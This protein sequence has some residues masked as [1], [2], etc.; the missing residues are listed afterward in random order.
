MK[1]ESSV[2]VSSCVDRRRFYAAVGASGALAMVAATA[3]VALAMPAAAPGCAKFAALKGVFPKPN[4][5]G[6]TARERIVRGEIRAPVWPGTCGKWF[7]RYRRGS[8]GVDVS[9][10]LYKTHE[11][12]LVALAE[13]LSAQ[14][15]RLSN[16]ALVRTSRSN[17]SVNGIAKKDASVASVYRNL[18]VTSV[19]IAYKPIGVSAQI[20]LHRHAAVLRSAEAGG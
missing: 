14:V 20:R 17:V 15:K 1:K 9:L 13:P 6:F 3:T 10:T 18:F 5:V 12:A 4:A 8:T 16:G 19:S 2:G 11:Q 7:T